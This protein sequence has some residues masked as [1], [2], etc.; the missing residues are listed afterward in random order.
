MLKSSDGWKGPCCKIVAKLR[1]LDRVRFFVVIFHSHYI[2][3][4]WFKITLY[5]KF[6]N[7]RLKVC[8]ILKQLFLVH[9]FVY[10]W[11][12]CGI[13][14]LLI[15]I[16]RC[17]WQVSGGHGSA[18]TTWHQSVGRRAGC[19]ELTFHCSPFTCTIKQRPQ[20][21]VNSIKMNSSKQT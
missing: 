2:I 6:K 10:L 9:V 15:W 20:K 5:H 7:F 4:P 21:T 12:F 18:T 11:F 1:I 17:K 16:L 19:N 3:H 14:Q 8:A 13:S